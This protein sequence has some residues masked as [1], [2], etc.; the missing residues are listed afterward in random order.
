MSQQSANTLAN[1]GIFK[2]L[3][4]TTL[5]RLESR[6]RW[7]RVKNGQRIIDF[8]SDCNDVF[9]VIEGAVNVVNFSPT[10][11]E[12][13]FATVEAGDLFGEISAID[14]Q[15]RSATVVSVG[16]TLI[17]TLPSTTFVD[18]LKD[19]AEVTFELVQRMAKL[20][21]ADD[22]RI[23]ELSVLAATQR[24]YSELLRMAVP[25]VAVPDLWVV[26]PLP[27]LREIASRVSTTRETAARAMS[28]VYST[29]LL[30]RKGRN[31]YLMD[32]AKLEEFVHA[33]HFAEGGGAAR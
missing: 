23:M 6:C 30:R 16:Q 11:R 10:G 15:P 18:L 17:A 27:P 9:F 19:R 24:V 4:D 1:I 7:R 28:Q 31:L 8:G 29:G 3:G 21:R 26:R 32:K 25:D 13:A 5:R 14:R 12:I 2:N 20:V 22:V 33:L